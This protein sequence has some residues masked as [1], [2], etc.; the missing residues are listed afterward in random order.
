MIVFY[1]NPEDFVLA[2]YRE[3]SSALGKY[4]REEYQFIKGIQVGKVK[5]DQQKYDKPAI[6]AGAIKQQLLG[7]QFYSMEKLDGETRRLLKGFVET[8][9]KS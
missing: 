9:I 7:N 1:G 8:N 4:S 5:K 3:S 6:P 2:I